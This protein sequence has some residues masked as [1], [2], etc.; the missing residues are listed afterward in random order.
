M[1]IATC[2]MEVWLPS[3]ETEPLAHALRVEVS[4]D[5]DEMSWEWTL[6]GVRTYDDDGLIR[7]TCRRDEGAGIMAEFTS[8]LGSRHHEIE[9]SILEQLKV[10]IE[11]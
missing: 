9:A 8:E 4:V 11:K 10:K 6:I 2:D 5:L 1:P 7:S 3:T